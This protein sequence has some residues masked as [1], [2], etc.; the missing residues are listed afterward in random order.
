MHLNF[1][2]LLCPVVSVC[3]FLY[4]ALAK[5][6]NNNY[7]MSFRRHQSFAINTNAFLSG[8][9]HTFTKPHVYYGNLF[10]ERDLTVYNNTDIC[11]NLTV[12]HDVNATNF[13]ASG[14]Y[15]LDG[16]VLVPAGT[17]IMS[18]ALQTPAGYLLCDGRELSKVEYADLYAVIGNA[19]TDIS[20]ST[21]FKIPNMVGRV[22]V[23]KTDNSDPSYNNIGATGGEAAH[24]LT[25]QEMP[26]HSHS[27][28]DAY[29]AENGG[30]QINGNNVFGTNANTDGDNQFRWRKEDGSW[31][32]NKN[33]ANINTSGVG[34][35]L[36]HNNMQPYMVLRYL[37][38]Y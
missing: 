30:T 18:A 5:Y 33:D 31:T 34:G 13:R 9:L 14:N 7:N 11:G 8:R 16:Y 28:N 32:T 35:G 15:Y 2:P 1:K 22:A 37:I 26:S 36:A 27:Y 19:Y 25:V 38:K 10:I 4:F 29:F 3:V 21:T 6:R 24:T 23:G 20:S 12:A 17:I